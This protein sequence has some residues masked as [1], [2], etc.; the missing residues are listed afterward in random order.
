MEK[1][2]IVY[3]GEVYTLLPGRRYYLSSRGFKTLHREIWKDMHGNIPDGYHVHHKDGDPAN[4]ALENLECVSPKEHA[5]RHAEEFA[6]QRRKQMDY[7]RVFASAWHGSPEGRKFHSKLG[8][9]SWANREPIP[10][11][12]VQCG[13]DYASWGK[14]DSDRF[15][16]RSCIS[17]FNEASRRYYEDRNCVACGATFNVKKSKPQA[18]CSRACGWV[19]RRRKGSGL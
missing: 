7:A 15:C 12:C 3:N 8:R 16:S 2:R 17:R 9:E 4:N 19:V 6:E 13:G 5:A 1:H 18:T 11:V 14:R 10:R